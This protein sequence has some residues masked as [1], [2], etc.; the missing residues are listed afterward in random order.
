MAVLVL[1]NFREPT[2]NSA[3]DQMAANSSREYVT[4]SILQNRFP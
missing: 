4:Q 1:E 2:G 3:F